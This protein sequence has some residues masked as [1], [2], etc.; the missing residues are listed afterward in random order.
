MD[1]LERKTGISWTYYWFKIENDFA[2]IVAP[3]TDCA[4]IYIFYKIE[5]FGGSK[6][7]LSFNMTDVLGFFH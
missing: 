4:K 5:L 2:K 1:R 7:S 6:L 3:S